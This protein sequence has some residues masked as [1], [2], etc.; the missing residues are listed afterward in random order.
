MVA[1]INDVLRNSQLPRRRYRRAA[2][3]QLGAA[4]GAAALQTLARW[5]RRVRERDE[6]VHLNARELKDIGL[7]P[8]EAQWLADRPFWRD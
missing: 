1:L 2:L 8:A 3:Y 7:T 6:L 4:L 5:Q